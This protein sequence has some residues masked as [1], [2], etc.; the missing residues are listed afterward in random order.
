MMRILLALVTINSAIQI[1]YRFYL[2]FCQADQSST[3]NEEVKYRSSRKRKS[4]VT[5]FPAE[6]VFCEEKKSVTM[7]YSCRCFLHSNT[8]TPA[9]TYSEPRAL[10]I[11]DTQLFRLVQR[12]DLFGGEAQYHASC[13][14]Q[15]KLN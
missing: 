3:G 5:L 2:N 11:G 13:E 14:N 10:E 1:L 12:Q 9:N 8:E 7:I 15:F 6:C 4:T